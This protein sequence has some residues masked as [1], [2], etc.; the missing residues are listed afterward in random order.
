MV[1][2]KG[3]ARDGDDTTQCNPCSGTPSRLWTLSFGI[4]ISV[5][6][7]VCA[8]LAWVLAPK[9]VKPLV[10][11][12]MRYAKSSKHKPDKDKQAVGVS[13]AA[14]VADEERHRVNPIAKQAVGVGV[15]APV[16]D[17]ERPRVNPV[18]TTPQAVTH[19]PDIVV[20][21]FMQFMD[22]DGGNPRAGPTGAGAGGD[23]GA[24]VAAA[25]RGGK[26][27]V[28]AAKAGR[29]SPGSSAAVVPVTQHAPSGAAA[30]APTAAAAPGGDG[31]DDNGGGTVERLHQKHEETE[32]QVG[33]RV[34]KR[35]KHSSARV[36]V[37]ICC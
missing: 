26:Q 18:A 24:G 32:K 28:P 17:K 5:V 3:H 36:K 22:G 20:E 33:E 34:P 14:P 23:A 29:V 30:G 25:A 1:C 10:A 9:L 27:A 13:V 8:V 6:V 37:R 11:C 7:G 2:W 31:D 12:T 19:G 35:L 15:A 4:F 21:A 16:A